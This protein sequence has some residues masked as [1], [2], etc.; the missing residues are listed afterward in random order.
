MTKRMKQDQTGRYC[1]GY[2]KCAIIA[3]AMGRTVN[4]GM[5]RLCRTRDGIRNRPPVRGSCRISRARKV[6]VREKA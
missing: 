3:E 1:P 2:G 4:P 6:A 5:C